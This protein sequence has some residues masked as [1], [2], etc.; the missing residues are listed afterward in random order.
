MVEIDIKVLMEVDEEV[1][2]PT[3]L[4]EDVLTEMVEQL[5]QS[6]LFDLIPEGSIVELDVVVG[7]L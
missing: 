2:P 4:D 6:A 3:L 1:M 7:G 5:Q